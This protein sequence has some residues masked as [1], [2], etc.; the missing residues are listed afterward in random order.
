MLAQ[1]SDHDRA[2]STT[3]DPNG[4]VSDEPTRQRKLL[5]IDI[6]GFPERW[7]GSRSQAALREV[8]KEAQLNG[9]RNHSE[10]IARRSDGFVCRSD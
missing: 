1:D 3:E 4:R 6:D 8:D 9:K 5:H 2:R 7:N 10:V